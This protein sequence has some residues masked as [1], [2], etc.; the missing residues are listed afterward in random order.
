MGYPYLVGLH[1]KGLHMGYP[2]PMFCLRAFWGP[3]L[4]TRGV[5]VYHGLSLRDGVHTPPPRFEGLL[6]LYQET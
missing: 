5:R 3:Q 4:W 2:Y 1:Y 6:R